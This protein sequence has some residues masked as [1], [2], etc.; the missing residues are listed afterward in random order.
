M[1]SPGTGAGEI[2]QR[3]CGSDKSTSSLLIPFPL[4]E[5][6]AGRYLHNQVV[7]R[8]PAPIHPSVGNSFFPW[9]LTEVV[10]VISRLRL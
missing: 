3:L 7:S 10:Y 1:S 5:V 2:H 4:C 9:N 8:S 6:D